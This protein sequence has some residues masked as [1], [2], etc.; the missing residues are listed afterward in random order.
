MR[1]PSQNECE[2][3]LKKYAVPE[4]II[5]HTAMVRKVANFLAL[6][7]SMRGVKVDLEAVDKG[8]LL[9]DLMKMHCIKNGCR[10]AVEAQKVLAG[11]GYPEFGLLLKLHGLEEVNYFDDST[12]IE[13]KI[14]WYADKRVNH[15][16]V[17]SMDDR[18][19]YLKERYGSISK[20]KMA[21]IIGT[22]R[23]SK[24]VEKELLGLAG[25]SESLEGLL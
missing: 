11:L 19:K 15:D 22:E 9:H 5:A 12:P 8:A 10:H 3:L 21:E 18:Y 2:E 24:K 7:I 1:V 16:K 6:K 4:N 17:V 14:I 25:V 23:N 20:E 13:A